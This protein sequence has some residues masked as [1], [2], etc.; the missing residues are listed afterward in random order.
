MKSVF[1]ALAIAALTPLLVSAQERPEEP[2]AEEAAPEISPFDNPIF[3]GVEGEENCTDTIEQ[4]REANGLPLLD[5]RA[6]SSDDVMAFKAVDYDVDGCDVLLV[7]NG[8]IRP[9]PPI[10]DDD[11]PLLHPAQ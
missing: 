6:A 2:E 1:P 10:P 9:L 5:R 11:A 4:V 8:D 7:G 3:D